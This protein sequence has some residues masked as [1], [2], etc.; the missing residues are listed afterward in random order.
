MFETEGPTGMPSSEAAYLANLDKIDVVMPL[1][2]GKLQAD[3]TWLQ[4]DWAI[5]PHWPQSLPSI[6]RNASHL[7]MPGVGNDRAGIVTV[8]DNPALQ[9]IA[10]HNLVTL[11]TSGRFDSPWDGIYLDLEGIPLA[12]QRPLSDFL[13]I[14]S[15]E[16]RQSGL[17]VGISTRGRT[18][19][20][21]SDYED[22]YTYDFAVVGQTADYFDMQCYGYWNPSPR[23]ISPYWWIEACIQ[24]ALSK[25]IARE[26]I[27]LGL[28]NFSK[29][30]PESTSAFADEITYDRAI[31]LVADAGAALQWIEQNQNGTVR[32]YFATVGAGHIWIHNGD[33]YRHGLDLIDRYDLLGNTL[34]ITGAGDDLTWQTIKAWRTTRVY[35]PVVQ[36]GV[37]A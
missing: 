35:L 12:Y 32:E 10:A 3:G 23:S 37:D 15:D 14:L 31:Q 1:N 24:Y 4:E 5:S 28:G 8:L 19:D 33:T 9:A 36:K 27:T 20:M 21:G 13:Y 2:G 6:A 25:Q 26:R 30:W 17:I 18:G 11:A 22:A 29:Y 7:Y 34:F 16:I